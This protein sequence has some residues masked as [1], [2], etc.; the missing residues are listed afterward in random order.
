M[1]VKGT[2]GLLNPFRLREGFSLS[3]RAWGDRFRGRGG[4]R[5]SAVAGLP[6][7]KVLREKIVHRLKCTMGRPMLTKVKGF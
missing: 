4:V 5:V 2:N 6:T 7:S 1:N 3:Q